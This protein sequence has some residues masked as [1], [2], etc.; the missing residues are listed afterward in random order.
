VPAY[1]P[2]KDAFAAES[3]VDDDL[4]GPAIIINITW[5]KKTIFFAAAKYGSRPDFLSPAESFWC[6]SQCAAMACAPPDFINRFSPPDLRRRRR[7]W[8]EKPSLAGLTKIMSSRGECA[9]SAAYQ[10]R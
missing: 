10:N 5:P 8:I 4:L 2:R 7:Q 3:A 6:H 1:P 9:G